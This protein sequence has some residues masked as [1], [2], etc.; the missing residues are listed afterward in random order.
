M[1]YY[2]CAKDWDYAPNLSST[3]DESG[4]FFTGM[5]LELNI[6]SFSIGL[7]GPTSTS[8]QKEIALRFAGSHG[9][10]I[11]LNNEAT[12]SDREPFWNT[13]WI[14]CF[15]EEGERFFFGSLFKL[16]LETLILVD[17]AKNYKQS[18]GAFYKFDAALSGA[19]IGAVSRTEF[20]LF[21]NCIKS[22]F[23]EPFANSQ[24]D[25]FILDNFYAFTQHKTRIVLFPADI[26]EVAN[27]S[28]VD[29]IMHPLSSR[30]GA[31][32][33]TNLFKPLLL[34]L[35]PNLTQ[36]TM[37]TSWGRVYNFNLLSLLSLLDKAELPRSWQSII[38]KDY[39]QK[40]LESAFSV[41]KQQLFAAKGFKMALETDQERASGKQDLITIV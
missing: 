16:Q 24:L 38:I 25:A 7:Q 6:P 31:D 28:F 2:G 34:K 33:D 39:D 1:A 27:K 26:A 18:F 20:E 22:V 37:Q 5:S 8:K 36:I 12:P 9:M 3:D 29:M 19:D 32:D 23:G 30:H 14:S 11:R 40:W 15:P 17:S 4:P 10:L 21:D 35:F 41:E 13:A